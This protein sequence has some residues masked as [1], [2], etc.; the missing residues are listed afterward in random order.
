MHGHA[1]LVIDLL[2]DGP[3]GA[4]VKT[5]LA[6]GSVED[7]KDAAVFLND[8]EATQYTSQLQC[9]QLIWHKTDQIC[10]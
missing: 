9:E 4:K 6:K 10:K 8:E 2:G 5:P 3:R 7:L 1:E